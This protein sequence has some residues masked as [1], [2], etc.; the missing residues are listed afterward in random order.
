MLTPDR[1]TVMEL[2]LVGLRD[3]L[4]QSDQPTPDP[5]GAETILIGKGSILDSLG[6]VTLIVD[7]EQKLEDDHGISVTLVNDRAMSQKNSPF[8]TVQTLTDYIY[9]LVSEGG[10]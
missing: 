8:R 9:G 7:L 10:S 5:L 6:L 1:N 3:V 4:A 2:V